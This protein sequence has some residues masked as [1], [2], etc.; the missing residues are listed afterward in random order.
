M[1]RHALV[2]LGKDLRQR[3]RDRSGWIVAFVVPLAMAALLGTALADAGDAS[4][5]RVALVAAPGDARAAASA[6]A[7]EAWQAAREAPRLLLAPSDEPSARQALRDGEIKSALLFGA[8]GPRVL[9]R[10]REVFAARRLEAVVDRFLAESALADGGA[11]P[12]SRVVRR[13]PGGELRMLDF[14]APS[15]AVLFA[16]FGALAGVRALQGEKDTGALARL[17]AAPIHPL[18]VL[19]A[20]FGALLLTGLAQMV[21]LIA[22]TALLFGTRW[23]APGPLAALVAGTAWMAVGMT[24]F[25]VAWGGNAERGTTIA[26][27]S[28]FVL[29]LI[30]GQF[31]PPSGLPDVFETLQRL[32]PNG[33]ATRGFVDLAAAGAHGG[34]RTIAEPLLV[35]FAIGTAGI[36]YGVRRAHDALHRAAG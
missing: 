7:F 25:F 32:T 28:I 24:S 20:K 26:N 13:S 17:A 30:G 4:P 2:I 11:L 36:A 15:M 21:M 3:A 1:L 31:L 5:Q 10:Q 33:Q 35:T 23:G 14:F 9:A 8:D 6:A 19:V 16:S 34:L 18:S 29:A 22:A 27:V 12:P